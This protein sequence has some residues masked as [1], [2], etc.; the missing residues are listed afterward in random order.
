MSIEEMIRQAIHKEVSP[1]MQ[2]LQ[3]LRNSLGTSEEWSRDQAIAY[4][5]QNGVPGC[6]SARITYYKGK[7]WLRR[8]P[9]SQGRKDFFY[10][11]DVKSLSR[12]RA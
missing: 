11:S 1:I 10:A 9:R 4:L 8:T 7:G 2:E 12:R 6:D 5:K 3:E